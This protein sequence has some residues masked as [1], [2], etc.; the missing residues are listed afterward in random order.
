M[1]SSKAATELP[2]V[3]ARGIEG[4]RLIATSSVLKPMLIGIR[5]RSE[6]LTVVL[7]LE[8]LVAKKTF[9][10]KLLR[11]VL[12]LVELSTDLMIVPPCESI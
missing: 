9:F 7:F 12:I 10:V 5:R 8:K 2:G 4:R 3:N 1:L 11:N 6:R